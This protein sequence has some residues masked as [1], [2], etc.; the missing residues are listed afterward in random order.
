MVLYPVVIISDINFSPLFALISDVSSIQMIIFIET[1]NGAT[2]PKD[3][4]ELRL[5]NE[6]KL[7]ELEY[8]K[9]K[10][11]RTLK[12]WKKF[13]DGRD[14][15]DGSVIPAEVLDAWLR[16]RNLGI[17]PAGGR[18]AALGFIQ[19]KYSENQKIRY[20]YR[21]MRVHPEIMNRS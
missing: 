5:F 2:A 12:E 18:A 7:R 15:I 19:G 14:D 20:R 16:R 1:G 3:S 21:L 13:V 4:R 8:Y 9:D 11:H 17:D 10:Y 6:T